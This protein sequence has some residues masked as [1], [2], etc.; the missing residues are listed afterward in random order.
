MRPIFLRQTGGCHDPGARQ[1]CGTL[2]RAMPTRPAAGEPTDAPLQAPGATGPAQP[3]SR[4]ARSAGLIGIATMASRVLGLARD[5]V[6]AWLFGAGDQMDAFRVAFK[7]PNLVRDLFAEG[8]MTAAFVPTFTRRLTQDGKA[9]AFRLGNLVL[10]ALLVVTGAIAL[11]GILFAE[12]LTRFFAGGFAEVP[13][14]LALTV[15]LTRVMFPFLTLVAVAVAFMG[16]LNSLRHFFVPALSP[17]MF[18]VGAIIAAFV[19]VPVMPLAGWP[20]MMGLALGTLLGGVLQAAIQW[21]ALRREGFRLRFELAP[22]DPWLREVLFLMGPGLLGLAAV[23]INLV[24]NMILATGE[25]TGAVSWLDYAFRLMYLPI[26]VFGVSIATAAVPTIAAMASRHDHQGMR[27]T[28]SEGLRLMLMLNVPATVGLVVLASPI[29]ALI[30]ERGRFSP[31][32]TAATAA[33]LMFYAPGLIGYSAVKICS[34]TFYALRDARTPVMVSMLSVVV[35]VVLNLVLVR[36]IGYRGLALGT[37][38]AA[39][40]NA[41][42]LLWLLRGRLDGIE[43]RSIGKAFLKIAA[44]SAVMALV[45]TW[46]HGTF[47]AWWADPD[48]L[49]R[50][51]GVGA[52]IAAGLITIAGMARV[53]RVEEFEQAAGRV[54]GRLRMRR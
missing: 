38:T 22:R 23:Q 43:G 4:L 25:G 46:T 7:I 35:N 10:S 29:V 12:P 37:A 49:P 9:A 32:D 30:Y 51:I 48:F 1:R 34:P 18:N 20:A 33:A 54:L 13:G 24:V 52:S 16:M 28:V 45:V 53:L 8:A 40:V 50:L 44:A 39:L 27:R 21:P 5:V 3:G 42:V 2:T 15:Q 41:G 11:L 31:D 36:W 26:G 47:T 6:Y 14:K 19:F 17:A